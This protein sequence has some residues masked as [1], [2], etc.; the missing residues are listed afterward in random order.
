[1]PFSGK[2]N[3]MEKIINVTLQ[4]QSPLDR[5]HS[6]KRVCL[7]DLLLISLKGSMAVEAAIGLSLFLFFIVLLMLPMKIMNTRRQVQAALEN[8]GEKAAQYIYIEEQTKKGFFIN[9][10]KIS[11]EDTNIF[12]KS[13]TAAMIERE[14]HKILD[15]KAVGKLSAARSR[16]MAD[17]EN[18]DL[19]IDYEI[20]LPFPVFRLESV[21]QTARCCRRAWIGI[22]GLLG[23]GDSGQLSEENQTVYIGKGS[24]RY[25]TS[26]L[27]HYLYNQL[28]AVDYEQLETARNTNGGKYYPCSRCAGGIKEG[29]VYIMPSGISFHKDSSCS[30]I[31]AYVKAVPLNEVEY[32]G[33]CTYCSK[34]R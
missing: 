19:I 7:S 12:L 5:K 15:T 16:I 13:I 6:E 27:C 34:G 2:Q 14:M 32:L 29:T 26:R 18:I 21:K 1:M 11:G 4:V 33:P 24:T 28:T 9:T 8:V 25:H 30:S 3:R 31:T 10:G 22:D 20:N 23:V 17:G